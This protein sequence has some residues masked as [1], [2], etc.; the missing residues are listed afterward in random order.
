MD[1]RV[2]DGD[3]ARCPECDWRGCFWVGEDEIEDGQH[4]AGL[5]EGNM[6][7]LCDQRPKMCSEYPYGARCRYK[8][9]EATCRESPLGLSLTAEDK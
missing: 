4:E 6:S 9:C 2:Y 7:D 3:D 1:A 5:S 8:R